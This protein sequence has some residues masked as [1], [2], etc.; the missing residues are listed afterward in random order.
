[1]SDSASDYLPAVDAWVLAIVRARAP[2]DAA[3]AIAADEY[4]GLD[5]SRY[6]RWLDHHGAELASRA[7]SLDALERARML[8]QYVKS[9]VGFRGSEDYDDPRGNYLNDVIDR[10]TGSPVAMAVVLMA[11]GRRA[12]IEVSGVAFPGHFLVR[13][14]GHY[15]DPFEGGAPL[16]RGRLMNLARETVSD[17]QQARACLEPV[18]VRTVAVRL[19][20]N[21][22]RIHAHRGDHARALVVSDRL[23]ELT[24]SPAHRVDRGVHALALGASRAAITDF[25]AYLVAHPDGETANRAR[26]ELSRARRLEPPVVN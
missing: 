11:L 18:G 19:L 26:E 7:N 12:A 10:R 4:P 1:L 2:E 9:E 3:F 22:H 8:C 21:L 14:E 20:L 16:D 25:E 24:R 6:L 23:F 15:A 13:I 5:A 17:P